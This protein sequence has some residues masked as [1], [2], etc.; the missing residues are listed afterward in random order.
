[1][2]TA[3]DLI[4]KSR[5]RAKT[6][7]EDSWTALKQ[8]SNY[9]APKSSPTGSSSVGSKS[10]ASKT[11]SPENITQSAS[12]MGSGGYVGV[13]ETP[14]SL[15]QVQPT[16]KW[17][18]T[19]WNIIYRKQQDQNWFGKL[20]DQV[21]YGFGGWLPGGLSRELARGASAELKVPQVAAA[22]RANEALT[23]AKV[24][25]DYSKKSWYE[26]IFGTGSFYP[27]EEKIYQQTQDVIREQTIL[28]EL[29]T[30]SGVTPS[31]PSSSGDKPS[32]MDYGF[33]ALVGIALFIGL[34]QK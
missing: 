9:V 22:A 4:K 3:G 10:M 31:F 32:L 33:L 16:K 27:P 19:C 1:M 2:V 7:G 24:I 17:V 25:E 11:S 21:D 13:P 28:R 26:D 29:T 23:K 34:K 6:T 12:S 15:S 8:V 5:E 14:Y 20:Y 30:G 18:D